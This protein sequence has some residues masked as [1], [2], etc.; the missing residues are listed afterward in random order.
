MMMWA[1][2]FPFLEW[3]IASMLHCFNAVVKPDAEY[4][5]QD[6]QTKAKF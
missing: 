4:L 1:G 5:D 2:I 6:M 3:L